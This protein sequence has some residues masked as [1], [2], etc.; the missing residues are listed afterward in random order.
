M[1]TSKARGWLFLVIAIVSEVSASLSLKGAL[2]HPGLYVVVAIGYLVAFAGLAL[3]LR[4][5]MALGVAYGIWGAS[6][7]ALTALLSLVI[8]GEPLTLVM[9]IGI[10]VVIAGVLCVELGAQAA[11]REAACTSTTTGGIAR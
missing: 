1:K 6:G 10:V 11:H 8:F 4:T 3:V 9:G 2:D 5:G 7:V